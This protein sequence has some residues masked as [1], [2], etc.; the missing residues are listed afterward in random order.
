[1]AVADDMVAD[2]IVHALML[3]GEDCNSD[4]VLGLVR[5]SAV[6][7]MMTCAAVMVLLCLY[8]G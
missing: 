8:G 1:M 3:R 5:V 2:L 6:G 7:V 4:D